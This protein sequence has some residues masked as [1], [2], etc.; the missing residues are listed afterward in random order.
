LHE[1]RE[2]IDRYPDMSIPLCPVDMADD[3]ERLTKVLALAVHPETIG[4]EALAA[5][6][7]AHA[8]A[9]ANPSLLIRGCLR[10]G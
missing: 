2:K 1:R 9:K 7:R 5:F 3:R 8:L 6:H 10:L 4:T